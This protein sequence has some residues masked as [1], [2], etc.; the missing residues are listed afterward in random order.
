[1]LKLHL[2]DN[3]KS[4]SYILKKNLERFF[5]QILLFINI[6]IINI[7]QKNYI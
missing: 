1:M 4:I 2:I 5:I 7:K 3:I 6:Y